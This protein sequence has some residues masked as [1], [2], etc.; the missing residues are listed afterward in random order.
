[1]TKQK[2]NLNADDL[3]DL[4]EL[5][6][7]E[8]DFI[9]QAQAQ[10]FQVKRRKLKK[11]K[12][13]RKSFINKISEIKQRLTS[14]SSK[15]KINITKLKPLIFQEKVL[16]YVY[17]T[18]FSF[19]LNKQLQNLQSEIAEQKLEIYKLQ[20]NLQQEKHPIYQTFLNRN[21]PSIAMWGTVV[22]QQFYNIY[23]HQSVQ[24]KLE[25]KLETQ[26][27]ELDKNKI[28]SKKLLEKQKFVEDELLK[29]RTQNQELKQ[30]A[31]KNLFLAKELEIK[32]SN[33][34]NIIKDLEIELKHLSNKENLQNNEIK[35][36]DNLIK[37]KKIEMDELRK[38]ELV[39]TTSNISNQQKLEYQNKIYESLQSDYRRQQQMVDNLEKKLSKIEH[40]KDQSN[41]DLTTQSKKFSL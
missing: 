28:E 14:L 41:Q 33:Q 23:R 35:E 20:S 36:L 25:Q 5:R 3:N 38:K 19:F 10:D 39:L 29:E 34:Q 26:T 32:I 17:F 15:V 12:T 1:M 6:K 13:L 11:Q 16:F 40:Q 2:N 22:F 27:T 31:E 8:S 37:T 7:R 9:N 30:L 4:D 21:W 24:H 18:G